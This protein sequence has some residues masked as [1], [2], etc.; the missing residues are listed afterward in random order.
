MVSVMKTLLQTAAEYEAVKILKIAHQSTQPS[1]G[2]WYSS[3][4]Q[5]AVAL[6]SCTNVYC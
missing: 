2:Q 1:Y 4:T 5:W 3:A 6:V